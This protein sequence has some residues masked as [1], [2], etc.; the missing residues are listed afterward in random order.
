MFGDAF[1]SFAFGD[2]QGSRI[3]VQSDFMSDLLERRKSKR[4]G[5]DPIWYLEQ[6]GA[7]II[8]PVAFEPDA[9]S[10]RGDFYYNSKENSLYRKTASINKTY[11]WVKMR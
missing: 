4:I 10:H 9:N 5:R 11:V 2:D 1:G 7:N 3:N 8:K 6:Y